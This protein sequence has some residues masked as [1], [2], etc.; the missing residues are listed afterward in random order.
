VDRGL[1]IIDGGLFSQVTCFRSTGDESRCSRNCALRCSSGL[2]GLRIGS[3]F[4]A[5]CPIFGV[6]MTNLAAPSISII[7]PTLNE[8]ENISPLVSRT[9]AAGVPIR[10][11]VFVDDG[12][13]DGTRERIRELGCEFPVRLIERDRPA[14]SLAGAVLAGA[15]AAKGEFIVV[16]DADLSHPPERINDLIAPLLDNRADLVIGSRY[17]AGGSTP[18]WPFW[19]RILSRL[20]SALVY[21]LTGA[22]DSM[23]GFFAISRERLLQIAPPAIGFKIVFETLIH[24]GPDLRV[25]E[26]P[27]VFRDRA[28]GR[29][30]MSLGVAL[31]FFSRW[32]VALFRR[33]VGA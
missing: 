12:S 8:A 14:S 24:G 17:V 2:V 9:A 20:A 32:L 4:D 29:S 30:K 33:A 1:A 10:E 22:H 13:T 7:V 16:M 5:G 18:G 23:A 25:C 28:S 3:T 11:I 27:V 31:R 6:L 15:H 21:P 26:I 19:R